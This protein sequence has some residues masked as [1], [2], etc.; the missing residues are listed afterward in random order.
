VWEEQ[1]DM[2]FWLDM[3]ELTFHIELIE[4]IRKVLI[5]EN[6]ERA[7]LIR[8]R[9]NTSVDENRNF[10]AGKGALRIHR[11][12]SYKIGLSLK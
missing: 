11:F 8:M 5:N 10:E 1:Q 6:I 3:I 9:Y 12:G 7:Q 4:A 2:L